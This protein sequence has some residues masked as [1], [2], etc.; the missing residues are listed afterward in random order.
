ATGTNVKTEGISWFLG[1]Y[2]GRTVVTHSGG[3]TGFITDLAMLPERQIA[4]VW[5][6]NCD[7]I[8]D[9]P[10]NG[11]VTYAAL[12]VALGLKPKRIVLKRSLARTMYFTFR[13]NGIQAAL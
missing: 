13:Q 10:I 7:W 4:V 8:D 6:A 5:M 3:D 2:R 9:G 11:P 1:K 12:D